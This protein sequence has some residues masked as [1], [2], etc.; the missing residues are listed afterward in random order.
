MSKDTERIS[1]G[2]EAIFLR[3]QM[4]QKRLL[5]FTDSLNAYMLVREFGKE[6]RYIAPWKKWVVWDDTHFQSESVRQLE[7]FV[8]TAS[9]IPDL[10]AAVD[11][12]D[13]DP[14]L[15]NGKTA[16]S[17]CGRGNCYHT[18]RRQ[19]PCFHS[20]PERSR[21]VFQQYLPRVSRTICTSKGGSVSFI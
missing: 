19:F 11:N 6:I 16:R 15:L 21:F 9:W 20:S 12:L 14:K 7:A 13:R 17:I 5:Q 10:N 8:K 1:I 4:L 3:I 18:D 2:E